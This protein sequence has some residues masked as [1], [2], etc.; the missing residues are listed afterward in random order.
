MTRPRFPI[1]DVLLVAT[2]DRYRCYVC[3]QGY[4]PTDPWEIDHDTSVKRGG[5]HVF[6]NLKLAHRSCNRAKGTA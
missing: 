1:S 3:D 5:G 4:D 2:R 6:T